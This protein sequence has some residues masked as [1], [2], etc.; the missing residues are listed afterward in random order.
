[1]L[2]I[3]VLGPL[4][5]DV[6]GAPVELGAP[7]Q[8]AVLALLIAA[9]G[10]VVSVDRMVDE[11]WRGAPPTKA[12][13]SLQ[14]YVSNLRR[15][16]EPGRQP[17]TPASVLVSVAPGY[18]LRLP[19]SAVD[20]WRFEIWVGRARHASAVPARELLA[21]ALG[22]WQGPA[23]L[24]HADETWAV[25]EVV[26][27]DAL[28]G[29]AHELAVAAALRTGHTAEA[30]LAAETM[31]RDRP[32]REEGWRLLAL[33]HWAAGHRA[34][35]LAALRRARAILR[36][37]LGCD[38]SPPLA[39]LE[40]AVLTQRLEVLHRAVPASPRIGGALL[41]PASPP[42]G[43]ALPGMAASRL[44]AAAS[45]AA[46][47]LCPRSAQPSG[48][49]P[50]REGAGPAAAVPT[51]WALR[52]GVGGVAP[53][54]GGVTGAGGVVPVGGGAGPGWSAAGAGVGAAPELSGTAGSG[55]TATAGG[56][57]F[58]GR[59]D[60]LRALDTTARAARR[61]GGM[62][63]VAGE[64][65]AG[66]SALL[67]RFADRL[68]GE[69]W[70]VVAGRCPEDEGAPPAW[71]WTEALGALAQAVPPARPE[72]L[73]ALLRE[74]D[75]A[76]TAIGDM[77]SAGSGG[78]AP[79][80]DTASPAPDSTAATPDV[81]IPA[82]ENT[83]TTPGVPSPRPEGTATT[84]DM[85]DPAPENTPADPDLPNPH[86][87]STA[88]A[89]DL[90]NPHPENTTAATDLA[91]PHPENTTAATDLPNPHP[92]NTTAATDLPNPHPENT[93]AA[94]DLPNPHP[95]NTTAATDL[96]N[97]HP[98][99]TTA[100]T[101][102]PNPHP[103]NTTAATDLPNPHPENTTPTQDTANPAP[104]IT[105]SAPSTPHLT[106]ATTTR[107]EATAGRFRL[108]RAFAAWLRDAAS[109]Q[110]V[111]VVVEDLHR[112][113]G[114]TLALLEAAASVAGV[115]LL[116]VGCYRP[117]EVNGQL[118]KTL[119]QLAPRFP[120]RI[121]LGG[122]SRRDVATV[123]EAVR[124][125]AVAED[126]IT[127]LAE[128]TGGNP[129]YVWESARLLADEGALVA[130]SEVPQGV[131][132][133]LR[134][135]LALL[136]ADALS[137]VRLAAVAG[138]ESDVALLVDAAQAD[139]ESV[140]AGLD[141]AVA[142][143]LLTEPGP[144]RV[145]FVHALV[146]D[147]VYT[148]L[149]G[150]RRARLHDRIA[151][152]LRHH[153]PDDLAALAHHFARSGRTANAPLAVDYALRAAERAERRYA[154]DV[155]VGL[156]E[157][158]LEAH[159]AATADPEG[160]PDGTVSL[161]VRL[162]G[163]QVRAGATGGALRTRGQAVDLAVRAGRDDLVAAVYGGWTEPSPWRSRLEGF[164]DRTAL[165]HLERLTRDPALDG[166]TRARVLQV[167]ADAVAG[168]DAPRA[169]DAAHAQLALARA[170]GEPRLLASALMTSA[171]VLPHE[172]QGAAR[173]PLVDE[174]RALAIAHDLPA[175]LW[176]CEHLDGLTA[177]TRNDPEAVRRH[178]AA[179]L[180][181][182]HRYRMRWARGINV[183]TSAM[184]AT[185]A[186]R[187]EEAEARYAEAD[188]LFQRVG[189]HH[190]TAPR[191]LGLWT[192][193][194]AQGRE[195]EIEADVR[196]VHSAIGT[197][198]AVALALV[199]AR[200]GRL[201]EARAVGYPAR[202]VTD[203]L[204]GMELDYRA[205][206]AVLLGDRDTAHLLIAHLLPLREQFAGTAGGAYATRPLA[207]AL[208]D[209][210]RF[211][212]EERR[213]RDAY[214]LAERVARAWGSPH[215]VAAASRSGLRIPSGA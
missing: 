143:D 98:E 139:E 215:H 31:V 67:G 61:A 171:R 187:F 69:G 182:A 150:T 30:V 208:G 193:R 189:A 117:A 68:R 79:V 29:E 120:H 47:A 195:A 94:T 121:S 127:A 111:A 184:L 112:A 155:A 165:A 108:H 161:L 28:C 125:E 44:A 157:Q 65:G 147:T 133:V 27:L 137:A 123:V 70:T 181:L 149:S 83:A 12:T 19:E 7:R 66:K 49:A 196:A 82:R 144:G 213:A 105:T 24:E 71:A 86:P 124:G 34:D 32:L 174:L 51:P 54:R 109:V 211:L 205:E 119:A 104:E 209:L 39:E 22:W 2:S 130:V 185:I 20:A 72:E 151:T 88:A 202:P 89:T 145:R 179:G 74:S 85:A 15:V 146:R 132:D 53:A 64:A 6:A 16:L 96:P 93:T 197:P 76:A 84:Q 35:A 135:R 3:R 162:L 106:H 136:P 206:V 73:A 23:F 91:N 80:R 14:T 134:R 169:L 37:E 212:G 178:T 4:G 107:D 159:L 183:A 50:G 95:E 38:L 113:D 199:L 198:V 201:E 167:L 138:L 21:E 59:T 46:A 100:A 118:A 45:T 153:R 115:P 57:L 8:R 90:P 92:E 190:A 99:N 200:Q 10:R 164:L 42:T 141:A 5:A 75:G 122:L 172:T 60:E 214:A 48:D 152:T 210:Y 55:R 192:I 25:P 58:V 188:G 97:P 43:G 154:H 101:D 166:P 62:V 140:L 207:H 177:A 163:A 9:R 26:R 186:G 168:E 158:A 142:A 56:G 52:G 33:A 63:L 170:D 194:L 129:F 131:R 18:A 128:R 36:D 176:V 175:H 173:T 11:L 40:H 204:Y 110:P 1:M 17:R 103:E 13:V 102:L 87:E 148:D 81:A 41:V 180:E 78:T 126:T 203:H 77:A 116:T 191:T 156:I 114:Q 160:D